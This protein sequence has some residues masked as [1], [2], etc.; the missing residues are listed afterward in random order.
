MEAN[1]KA[2]HP[3]ENPWVNLAINIVIPIF[4]W[5]KGSSPE[6]LGPK[7]ALLLGLAFPVVYALYDWIRYRKRNLV[8]LLGIVSLLLTGGLTL[9]HV[10][11]L[12]FAIKEAA[13]PL[14]IGI[15][16]LI[17]MRSQTPFLQAFL[18]NDRLFQIDRIYGILDQQQR[19]AEF[20]RTLQVTNLI[21]AGSFFLSSLINY[22]L[23]RVML[24]SEPQSAAFNEELAKMTG[25]SFLVITLPSMAVL[26]G[27]LFYL[28]NSLKRLT[29]LQFEEIMG[30]QKAKS[31]TS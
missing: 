25:M 16:V 18:F 30:E 27:A 13:I 31:L 5:T 14:V 12:W 2:S 10:S 3:P 4:I 28:L 7:G 11:L 1:P 17:S 8:S 26:A 19:R 22:V 20:G 24:K 9:L 15:F 23:A 29:G 6:H 21:V